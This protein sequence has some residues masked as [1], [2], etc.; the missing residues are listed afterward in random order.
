[1]F[2]TLLAACQVLIFSFAAANQK[3][4]N[5]GHPRIWSTSQANSNAWLIL[6]KESSPSLRR[7]IKLII[8]SKLCSRAKCKSISAVGDALCL[9]CTACL[10]CTAEP[11]EERN[12]GEGRR[13]FLQATSQ[14]C[15]LC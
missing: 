14:H 15:A 5:V 8:C 3:C 2:S 1:M 6:S 4:T 9:S 12:V 13:V 11:E 7:E 10:I